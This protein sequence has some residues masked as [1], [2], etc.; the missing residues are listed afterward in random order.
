[1]EITICKQPLKIIPYQ[2]VELPGTGVSLLSVGMEQGPGLTLWFESYD[3]GAKG[4]RP[5]KRAQAYVVPTGYSGHEII[6]ATY[7]GTVLD[8]SGAAWHVYVFGAAVRR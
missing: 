1:M 4:T 3:N 8:F 5:K 6:G 2:E 7:V